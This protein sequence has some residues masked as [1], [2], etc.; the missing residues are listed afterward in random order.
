MQRFE[1]HNNTIKDKVGGMKDVFRRFAAAVSVGMG[2]PVTF[3]AA[4]TLI[5]VW[6]VTGPIFHFSNTWQLFINTLTTITTFLMVFLIQ[7]T[8]NRDAK[9][10][11]IKLDELLKALRGARNSLVGA[12]EL[13]DKELDELLGEFRVLHEKYERE[14]RRKGGKL[15]LSVKS[16]V[17]EG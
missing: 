16:Q 12:E 1:L 2:K 6:A 3:V 7:N 10:L 4:V 8:Q 5:T 14:I 15:K 13:S 9:A 11:H 17:E